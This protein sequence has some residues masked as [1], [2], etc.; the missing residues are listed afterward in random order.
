MGQPTFKIE[1]IKDKNLSKFPFKEID[2]F[3]IK[4]Y[5]HEA[6]SE[7]SHKHVA[8][9][10]AEYLDNDEDGNA[11]NIALINELQKNN[12]AMIMFKN[13]SY[14]QSVFYTDQFQNCLSYLVVPLKF[15]LNPYLCQLMV[16]VIKLVLGFLFLKIA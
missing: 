7:N 5:A 14:M 1:Q 11:D 10:L 2:I 3:G 12:A 9:I 13:N 6:V 4:V 8:T 15:S 16:L